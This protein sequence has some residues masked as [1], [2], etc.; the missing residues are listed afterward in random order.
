MRIIADFEGTSG[1]YSLIPQKG[2]RN[3][4]AEISTGLGCT[5][6]TIKFVDSMTKEGQSKAFD[7]ANEMR[8]LILKLATP[9][10]L[11]EGRKAVRSLNLDK[12]Y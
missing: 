7:F 12:D 5:S 3:I 1:T 10:S 11:E 4:R 6:V 8:D 2:E 9:P